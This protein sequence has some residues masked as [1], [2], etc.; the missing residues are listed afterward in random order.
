MPKPNLPQV[1]D[2]KPRVLK[3]TAGLPWEQGLSIF[4]ATSQ[5]HLAFTQKKSYGGKP[6]QFSNYC[7]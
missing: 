6:E 1:R 5:K 3:K 7:K 4:A 2:G